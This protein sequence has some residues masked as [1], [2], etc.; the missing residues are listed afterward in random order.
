MLEIYLALKLAG[1]LIWS[2]V[3]VRWLGNVRRP[4][5]A[6]LLLGPARLLL[7]WGAGL[8]VAPFAIMAVGTDHVPL[9]YFTALAAVR[10]FEWGIIQMFIPSD[11]R[12]L[13]DFITGGDRNG[14]LWRLGGIGVSYLADAPFL[15]TQGFPHGRI[16]C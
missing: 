1:Y 4:L 14:R 7:G 12:S 13:A 10:W 15:L 2:Y 5:V 6:A 8:M 16:F 9:F 3:G 11:Q